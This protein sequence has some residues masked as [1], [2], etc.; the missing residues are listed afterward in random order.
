MRAGRPCRQRIDPDSGSVKS[1]SRY[2]SIPPPRR[3]DPPSNQN[4][5]RSPPRQS[6]RRSARRAELQPSARDRAGWRG[7]A[8][9]RRSRQAGAGGA[10]P[11]RLV[12]ANP[13]PAGLMSERSAKRAAGSPDRQSETSRVLRLGSRPPALPSARERGF[14]TRASGRIGAINN[15]AHRAIG[16]THRIAAVIRAASCGTDGP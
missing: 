10:H 12:E 15:H 11:L 14:R 4:R 8:R 16:G 9:C 7:S 2:R 5:P 13:R 1:T 6:P 3:L